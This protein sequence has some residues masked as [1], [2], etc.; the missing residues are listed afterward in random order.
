LLNA[1]ALKNL[2]YGWE[3]KAQGPAFDVRRQNQFD[4][5][6]TEKISDWGPEQKLVRDGLLTGNGPPGSKPRF[7]AWQTAPRSALNRHGITLDKNQIRALYRNKEFREAVPC[8]CPTTWHVF[9]KILA[10]RFSLR[11]TIGRQLYKKCFWL[12]L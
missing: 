5:R 3:S 7:A 11:E 4:E 2:R 10:A 8:S 9:V 6:V 12:G 1:E